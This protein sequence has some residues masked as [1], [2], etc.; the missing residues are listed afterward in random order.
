V[1]IGTKDSDEVVFNE[2]AGYALLK[3]LGLT[4]QIVSIGLGDDPIPICGNKL[5]YIDNRL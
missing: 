2:E 3:S 4:G 1:I 5:L